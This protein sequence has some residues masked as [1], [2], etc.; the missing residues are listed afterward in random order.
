[1]N[2][3]I[4]EALQQ[5]EAAHI[6]G[7]LQEAERVYRTI[8][9]AQPTH[10]YANHNLGMLAA[11]RYKSQIALPFFEIALEE[12]PEREEFW[13]SYIRALIS[14]DQI[15]SAGRSIKT[16]K[17]CGFS[18]E[19]FDALEDLLLS[20]TEHSAKGSFYQANDGHYLNFLKALHEKKYEIYF[21]IGACT[22]NSLRL[23]QSPSVAIDPYF[24]LQVETIGNKDFCL[25]FQEKSDYFF[26]ETLPKFP[27]LKCQLG[28]IDGMHLFEYALRD[29]INLAKNSSE[30]PLFL[31]HDVLPWSYE[32]ATRDYKKIPKGEPWTGD[33]WKLIPIFISLGM[34][35]NMKLLTS[36]P[37][38]ILAISNPSKDLIT[39]LEDD[40]DRIVAEWTDLVLD[41][42][43]LS[44][45]YESK[46]FVKPEI[47]LQFL[48]NQS[49]GEE[50]GDVSK[51]WV[52]H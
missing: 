16:A 5:G 22:G 31:F 51:E 8:L 47:Y 9:E 41:R 19:K 15:E 40:F 17:K 43:S 48:E 28:F 26:G 25:L 44:A 20:P 50:L 45:L 18:S 13:L 4:E 36:A 27:H 34:E 52:S 33:I 24:N 12:N 46:V 11:S 2:L 39:K 29:F 21:E 37:S 3:T 23:S 42:K 7:K 14:V 38:G 6:E 1:M 32:M 10:P 30:K 49:F 35:K